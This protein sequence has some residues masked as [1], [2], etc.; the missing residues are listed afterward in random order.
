[1]IIVD[2]FKLAV[3]LGLSC[4]KFSL[5][6]HRTFRLY[7]SIG[8]YKL[9]DEV[10][11]LKLSVGLFWKPRKVAILHLSSFGNEL[12]VGV[13]TTHSRTQTPFFINRRAQHLKLPAK[14]LGGSAL[15]QSFLTSFGWE[16][17]CFD[18][19]TRHR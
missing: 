9:T 13:G 12:V 15:K 16:N 10:K 11:M 17:A 19:V 14:M 2:L 3:S 1:M 7:V 4:A 18:R 6:Y 8:S 5:P